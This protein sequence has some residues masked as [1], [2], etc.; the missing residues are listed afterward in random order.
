MTTNGQPVEEAIDGINELGDRLK[1]C[2][3]DFVF[4]ASLKGEALSSRAHC[5]DGSANDLIE[6]LKSMTRRLTKIMLGGLPPSAG[7]L[8]ITLEITDQE[9]VEC[10][11]DDN[12][13]IILDLFH[14][15][16]LEKCDI[17]SINHTFS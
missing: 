5:C 15:T 8:V 14:G 13:S 11:K 9:T 12:Q 7:S 16:L 3:V 1:E 10:Y 2:E 17:V 6:S 4:V